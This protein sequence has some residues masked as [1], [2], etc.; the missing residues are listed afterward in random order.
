MTYNNSST[1]NDPVFYIDGQ[2]QTETES[3]TPAG[4]A[5]SDAATVARI[6][7]IGNDTT[8]T[9]DGVIDEVRLSDVIR[10]ADWMA[11]QHLSMTDTFIT[12]NAA[13]ASTGFCP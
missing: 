8:R 4:S 1:A 10:S 5:D 6:G 2:P 9:F 3:R 7:N 13:E 11:A 12:Y